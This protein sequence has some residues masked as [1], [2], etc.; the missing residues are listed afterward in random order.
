LLGIAVDRKDMTDEENVIMNKPVSP[1]PRV[2]RIEI[3]YEDGS[4]DE[5]VTAPNTMTR[6]PLFDWTRSSPDSN[7][8]HA[9]TSGAVAAVLFQ[10]AL[11]RRLMD[12]NPRDIDT[13]GLL[14]GF[15][16]VWR[17]NDYPPLE[18]NDAAT[19]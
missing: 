19:V 10:T 6:I 13:L 17:D 2:R 16:H 9:R 3:H 5:I 1:A 15:A 12:S 4:K 14:R 8:K 7:F 11:T 18:P